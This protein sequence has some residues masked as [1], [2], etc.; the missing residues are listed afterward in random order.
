M[1]ENSASANQ[2]KGSDSA[3]AL[4][5]SRLAVGGKWTSVSLGFPGARAVAELPP[6][7]GEMFVF[8]LAQLGANGQ[9]NA[10]YRTDVCDPPRVIKFGQANPMLTRCES[11]PLESLLRPAGVGA[12]MRESSARLP[13]AVVGVA[14]RSQARAG[15]RRV[16]GC[17]PRTCVPAMGMPLRRRPACVRELER[18]EVSVRST[19][20]RASG[21]LA[22]QRAPPV[23]QLPQPDDASCSA[24]VQRRGHSDKTGAASACVAPGKRRTTFTSDSSP[25]SSHTMRIALD[26][27]RLEGGTQSRI[28]IDDAV[29]AEYAETYREHG[30]DAL[31]AVTVFFDGTSYWLADG[32]HRT[33]GACRAGL[34]DIDVDLRHG[35]QREAILWSVGANSSHGLR[36]TN[37]DKRKAV[38]TLLTDAEW[39]RWSDS[40]IARA[41]GVSHHTVTAVRA[42]LGNLPSEASGQPESEAYSLATDAGEKP[43]ERTYITKHGTEATMKVGA[44][45]ARRT[46]APQSAKAELASADTPP[47][48]PALRPE[49]SVE[50][51][52]SIEEL[53]DDMRRDLTVAEEKVRSL[54]TSDT[55]AEILR[56]HQMLDHANRKADEAQGKLVKTVGREAWNMKQLLR[57]GRAVGED[58]PS[59]I[60]SRVEALARST[61]TA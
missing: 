41:C 25:W 37:A 27:I 61:A 43:I 50:D 3:A 38:Q 55:G 54:S 31:P 30:P 4:K 56:L 18:C 15:R 1:S 17:V 39:G 13:P 11:A 57:C 8:L 28:A 40:A 45:G 51:R 34:H 20:E 2:G 16:L 33:L 12:W 22:R 48:P 6:N 42:S 32:F 23:P 7:A 5:F 9:G 46:A 49:A 26:L 52:M 59:R 53:L 21:A 60:A 24:A 35:T 58:D 14:S 36:R 44:I 10:R 19:S 29:V 47:Q